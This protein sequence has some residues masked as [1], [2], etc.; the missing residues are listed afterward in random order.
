M[1]DWK[2]TKGKISIQKNLSHIVRSSLLFI[3]CL[4]LVFM[5]A[6]QGL[7]AGAS[8]GE[9]ETEEVILTDDPTAERATSAPAELTS[10]L[11][12][13][14][15]PQET[16]TPEA[17]STLIPEPT[18]EDYWKDLPVVPTEISDRMR[19][20]YQKGLENGL[21]PHRFTRIGD[22]NSKI[23]DFLSG[24]DTIYYLGEYTYLQPAIDFFKGAFRRPSQTANP[25]MTTARLLGTLWKTEDCPAD[26]SLLECQYRVDQA[27]FVLIML[28]TNDA[29]YHQGRPEAFERNMRR[30]IELTLDR[31]IVPVLA[32]KADNNEGDYS[33][34]PII[35]RLA[36]E[37][38]IPL[39]NFWRAAQ[40][41]ENYGL[42]D[43]EHLNSGSGAPATDFTMEISLHYGKE[44]KNLTGLQVLNL[45]MEELAQPEAAAETTVSPSTTP[46]P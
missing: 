7:T 3:L 35:A 6:C 11:E 26:E 25:G 15:T 46:Q 13:T 32:T 2:M 43:N 18:S 20:V 28:G 29:Y 27:S 12:E 39:W 24:F 8:T 4:L 17:T 23:P 36:M 33:I 38:E 41:L 31:G 22:C 44:M 10:T 19:E 9:V 42:R 21:N 40:S 34:N 5:T 45:L 14:Q 37:Y 30:I 1:I 16:S